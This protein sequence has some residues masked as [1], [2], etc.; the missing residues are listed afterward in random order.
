MRKTAKVDLQWDNQVAKKPRISIPSAR[1]QRQKIVSEV[2]RNNYNKIIWK[3]K[4]KK[5]NSVR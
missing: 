3:K 4:N 1:K 2:Y 5:V